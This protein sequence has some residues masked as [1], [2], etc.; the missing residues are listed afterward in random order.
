MLCC[1]QDVRGRGV[2]DED[3]FLG[4]VRHI[5][6]VD[7]YSRTSDDTEFLSGIQDLLGHL[8][9]GPDDQAVV[10]YEVK[11]SMKGKRNPNTSKK[12]RGK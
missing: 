4:C 11:E 6:I 9:T 1:R 12:R 3:T 5:D 8:G 10:V 7:T 2:H